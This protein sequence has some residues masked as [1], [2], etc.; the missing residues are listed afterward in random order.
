MHDR[1]F[2]SFRKN[3]TVCPVWNTTTSTKILYISRINWL[4][5]YFGPFVCHVR[6]GRIEH[7]LLGWWNDPKWIGIVIF[8]FVG[9]IIIYLKMKRTLCICTLYITLAS[10][11]SSSNCLF[12]IFFPLFMVH[13]LLFKEPENGFPFLK[14][15]FIRFKVWFFPRLITSVSKLYIYLW[16]YLA[17]RNLKI[18]NISFEMSTYLQWTIYCI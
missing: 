3:T 17:W 2:M 11:Y 7:M 9:I 15:Q 6:R 10:P 12:F 4:T 5:S 18:E 16:V 1:V 8:L 13:F 14:L